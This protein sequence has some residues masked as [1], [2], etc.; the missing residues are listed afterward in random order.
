M[1]G[2]NHLSA[3]L[4]GRRLLKIFSSA[5]AAGVSCSFVQGA[6]AQSYTVVDLGTPGNSGS[7]SA[8]HGISASGA[9]TGEWEATNSLFTQSFLYLNGTNFDLG[10]ISNG[11]GGTDTIAD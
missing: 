4:P 11:G 9:V 2:K 1:P 8:A 10:S 7:Y 6:L 5:L 3:T